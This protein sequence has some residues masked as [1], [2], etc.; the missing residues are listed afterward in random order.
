MIENKEPVRTKDGYIKIKVKEL[1]KWNE[2]NGEGC[3][4]SDK[5]TKEGYK[6]GY[7]YR[8][9]P[10]DG[11]PDSGWRFMAGNE[12]DEYNNN[13]DNTHVFAVNTICNY[14]PDIV[15][16]IHSP[17]GSAYIRI[18]ENNFELDDRSKPI[19]ITKQNI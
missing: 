7:M 17:I 6:V 15:P 5:I 14:D 11:R 4:V 16:Y 2:P 1:I 19:Y 9:K 12:S 8:E 18:D 3:L 10:D 13:P